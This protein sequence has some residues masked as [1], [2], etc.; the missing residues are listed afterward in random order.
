VSRIPFVIAALLLGV[1]PA[2]AQPAAAPEAPLAAPAAPGGAQREAW[3]DRQRWA[4]LARGMSRFDVFRVLGEPGKV[5]SYDG[6]ERWEYPDMLG[7]R[8]NFNDDGKLVGWRLPPEPRPPADAP[9][10]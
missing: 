3:R 10:R 1:H 7:G 8:V 4:H 2:L 9:G 5:A 6:F